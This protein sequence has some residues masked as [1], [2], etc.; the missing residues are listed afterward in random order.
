MLKAGSKRLSSDFTNSMAQAMEQA[1]RAEWPNIMGTDDPAPPPSDQM[2]LLF[3]AI[4][5]GVVRHLASHP[6]AFDIR[7][8]NTTNE[9]G[10][11][12]RINTIGTLY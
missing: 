6:E 2:R 4:A 11:V 8:T 9:T 3:I 10:K 5:Q 1:F 7:I 12:S